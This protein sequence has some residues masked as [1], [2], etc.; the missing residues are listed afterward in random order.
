MTNSFLVTLHGLFSLVVLKAILWVVGWKRGTLTRTT[1]YYAI[2]PRSEGVVYLCGCDSGTRRWWPADQS[3]F[4]SGW[5]VGEVQGCD[6]SRSAQ[7]T[8]TEEI[9][10]PQDRASPRHQATGKPPAKKPYQMSPKE[11]QELKEIACRVVASWQDPTLEGSLWSTNIVPGEGRR[12]SQA[13]C[14]TGVWTR[15]LW[16]TSIQ[17]FWFQIYLTVYRR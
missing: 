14:F 2:G 13:L 8:S 3:P 17:S 11:L 12:K 1:L 16:R 9:S 10:R 5:I 4:C 15:W 6:A 7:G